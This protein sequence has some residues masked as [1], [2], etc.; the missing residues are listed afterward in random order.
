MRPVYYLL[1]LAVMLVVVPAPAGYWD[2][3]NRVVVVVTALL[4]FAVWE[5]SDAIRSLAKKEKDRG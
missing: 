3:P 1:G 4:A 2:D 5:I